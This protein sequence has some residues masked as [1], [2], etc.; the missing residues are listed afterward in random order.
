[1]RKILLIL[2][3]SCPPTSQIRVRTVSSSDE[4]LWVLFEKTAARSFLE[5]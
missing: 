5:I 4:F 1:M 2:Y 3:E